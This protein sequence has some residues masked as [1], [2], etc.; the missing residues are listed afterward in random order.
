[1]D[2]L[3]LAANSVRQSVEALLPAS[4]DENAISQDKMFPDAT[5]D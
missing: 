2:Y 3:H 5:V 1:M 4:L